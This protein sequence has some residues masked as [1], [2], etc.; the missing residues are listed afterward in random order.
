MVALD[1]INFDSYFRYY[2]QKKYEARMSHVDCIQDKYLQEVPE[3]NR[4]LFLN[5][6]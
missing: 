1:Q 3:L 5:R 4:Y 6:L 2:F